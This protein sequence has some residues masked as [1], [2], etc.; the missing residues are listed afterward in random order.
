MGIRRQLRP[1]HMKCI[2]LL[3][4]SGKTTYSSE[5]S[6]CPSPLRKKRRGM[7]TNAQRSGERKSRHSMGAEKY[8]NSTCLFSMCGFTR[9][10]I[11]SK[12]LLQRC[13]VK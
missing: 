7:Q 6:I 3:T 8:Q 13:E 12:Q 10:C 4:A 2:N 11:Y 5:A 1:G 9:H